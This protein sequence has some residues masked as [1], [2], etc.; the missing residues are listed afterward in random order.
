[1]LLSYSARRGDKILGKEERGKKQSS[2]CHI[3]LLSGW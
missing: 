2:Y 1:M 3:E